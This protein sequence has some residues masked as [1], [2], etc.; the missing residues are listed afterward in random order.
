MRATGVVVVV[1]EL[2][3]CSF[4][5]ASTSGDDASP[6]HDGDVTGSEQPAPITC[7]PRWHDHSIAFDAPKPVDNL[8]GP[9][10]SSSKDLALSG[11]ELTLY[12][13]SNRGSTSDI[14]IYRA[15]RTALTDEFDHVDTVAGLDSPMPES[16]FT[17]AKDGLHGVLAANKPPSA[18]DVD[19]LAATRAS[20]TEKFALDKNPMAMLND[21]HD[22]Y[23]PVLSDDGL[24][25]YFA[26]FVDSQPVQLIAMATRAMID[27]DFGRASTVINSGMGDGDP[28]L[29]PDQTVMI[30]SSTRA[31][32]SGKVDA[33]Y[34][35]RDTVTSPWSDA[36]QLG[37]VD[38]SDNESDTIATR[39]GC[40]LYF[41]SDRA[42]HLA[43]NIYKAT[44]HD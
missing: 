30:F 20:T 15:T 32:G 40:A 11:D 1:L 28:Y 37:D 23:D 16:H 17:V 24:T 43:S 4:H 19:L 39:D 22:Q 41:A 14:S 42:N 33:W 27:A 2:C 13:S 7:W 38:T 18:G 9:S 44:S 10:V 36:T 12:F 31:G 29:S 34:V 21:G 26:P 3:A 6:G 25:L 35:V 5:P 8:T